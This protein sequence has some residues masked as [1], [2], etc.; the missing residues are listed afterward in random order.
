MPAATARLSVTAADANRKFSELLRNVRNG[1]SVIITVH[2]TP[3][4][5]IVPLDDR[6]SSADE[7]RRTLLSRLGRQRAVNAGP[8]TR[9]SLYGR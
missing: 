1:K 8:W 5:K 9:D 4:A 7:G 2:G 3:V 6:T